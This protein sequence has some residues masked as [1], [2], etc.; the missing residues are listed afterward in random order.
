M[1]LADCAGVIS[2]RRRDRRT[3]LISAATV[4][5]ALS[6]LT[7]IV[8]MDYYFIAIFTGISGLGFG[9]FSALDFAL[10]LDVLQNSQEMALDLG[11]WHQVPILLAACTLLLS[12]ASKG[13][14]C[15]GLR[16]PRCCPGCWQLHWQV[17]F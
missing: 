15:F 3:L 9:V 13:S 12:L 5:M 6:A 11:V 17:P 10:A 14:C 4:I 7:F 2:D 16:R 1:P 8:L